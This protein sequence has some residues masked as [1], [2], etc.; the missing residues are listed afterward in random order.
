MGRTQPAVLLC[1][2]E[3]EALDAGVHTGLVAEMFYSNN[4]QLQCSWDCVGN[5]TYGLYSPLIS[6]SELSELYWA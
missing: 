4:S 1:L 3:Q 6:H 5:K 2:L